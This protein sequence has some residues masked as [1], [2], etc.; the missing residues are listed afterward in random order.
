MF[1]VCLSHFGWAYFYRKT[2]IESTIIERIGMIASPSFI[3]ISGVML[4]FL[5]RTF[6]KEFCRIQQRLFDR[7]IFLLTISHLLNTGAYIQ[8]WGS[9]R[10]ALRYVFITDSIGACIIV[11]PFLVSRL[12]SK[13]RLLVS[14]TL[15]SASWLIAW[16]WHPQS[17]ALQ[18]PKEVLFGPFGE[19]SW[20]HYTFPL[21]PWF[22]LYLSA[23]CVGERIGGFVLANDPSAIK[24]LLTRL[25]VGSF[26]FSV[27]LNSGYLLLH[28]IDLSSPDSIFWALISP[29]QKMPP[30]PG[31]F[32]FYGSIGLFLLRV[33]IELEQRSIGAKFIEV[34]GIMG[35]TSLFAFLIQDYLYFTLLDFIP[36]PRTAFWPLY[37]FS[38]YAL[39]YMACMLWHQKGYNRFFTVGLANFTSS[40]RKID[41]LIITERG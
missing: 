12:Q 34:A 35:Q 3:I 21:V 30:S 29:F 7:G 6:D 16:L 11:G 28:V 31:Y 5:Y 13:Y 17:V 14:V 39:V 19:L 1:F 4:G 41:Q 37:F 22:S 18:L 2:N 33:C 20:L 24:T 10:E 36:L 38:S 25:A 15:Y 23:T 32:A 40:R 26:I 9:F 8:V 27:L